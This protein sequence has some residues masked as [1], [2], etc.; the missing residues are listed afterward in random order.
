MQPH[1]CP[2]H[3][4]SDWVHVTP[5]NPED[6]RAKTNADWSCS[7]ELADLCV[8]HKAADVTEVVI[9]ITIL[10]TEAAKP[11]VISAGN[12]LPLVIVV[13]Y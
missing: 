5:I 9:N 2:A 7:V 8:E 6:C 4:I 12:S 3:S 10:N 13:C 1:Q 11:F